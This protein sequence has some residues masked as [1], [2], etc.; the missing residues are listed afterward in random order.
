MEIASLSKFL[1]TDC[2]LQRPRRDLFVDLYYVTN[3]RPCDDCSIRHNCQARHDLELIAKNSAIT[4]KTKNLKTNKTNQELADEHGVSKRQ[5]SKM[6]KL[7]L[8]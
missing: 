7:G 5:I 4:K 8:I 6:R 3:G 1:K 2:E